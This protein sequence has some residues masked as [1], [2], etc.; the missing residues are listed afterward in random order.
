MRR[1]ML[2]TAACC[3]YA[4]GLQAQTGP[5][6]AQLDKQQQELKQALAEADRKLE[7]RQK[8]YLEVQNKKV[9]YDTIGLGTVPLLKWPS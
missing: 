6:T 4:A 8:L 2:A 3:F 5:D 1:L 9:K 7:E